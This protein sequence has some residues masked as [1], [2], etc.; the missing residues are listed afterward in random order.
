[1]K[2][3]PLCNSQ[4]TPPKNSAKTTETVITVTV[5]FDACSFDNHVT[6]FISVATFLK[7]FNIFFITFT[8][9]AGVM[10]AFRKKRKT[11]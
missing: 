1:M 11:F 3:K 4:S 8:L 10:Y 6:L 2:L 9:F 7:Y 5:S